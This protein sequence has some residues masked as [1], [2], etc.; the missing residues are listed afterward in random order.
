MPCAWLDLRFLYEFRHEALRR[1]AVPFLRT[2]RLTF[3]QQAARFARS[4]RQLN[5]RVALKV[6]PPVANSVEVSLVRWRLS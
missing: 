6:C 4:E 2:A 3:G 5:D 1:F